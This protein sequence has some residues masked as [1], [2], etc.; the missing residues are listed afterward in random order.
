[1]A[2]GKALDNFL[3]LLILLL[4]ALAHNVAPCFEVNFSCFSL[5][6]RQSIKSAIDFH[7]WAKE[8]F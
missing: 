2:L 5:C 1:M 7:F 6:K 8:K 3:L 4:Y